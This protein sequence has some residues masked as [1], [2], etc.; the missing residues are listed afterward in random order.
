LRISARRAFAGCSTPP[1]E[2]RP[3]ATQLILLGP[4]AVSHTVT[5][6]SDPEY[7]ST[8]ANAFLRWGAFREISKLGYSGNDLTGAGLTPVTRFK[9]QLG[10]DLTLEKPG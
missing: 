3:V 7:L 2:D 9:S 10:G 8:G 6:G 5:A 1:A 4:G